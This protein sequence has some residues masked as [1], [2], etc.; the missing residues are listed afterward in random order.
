MTIATREKLT[1]TIDALSPT[2]ALPDDSALGSLGSGYGPN[3]NPGVSW[4][5]G[6]AGTKSYALLV[7]D[8]DVPADLSMVNTPGVV[9]AEHAPRQPFHHLVLV[10]VPPS[11]TR[12]ATGGDSQGVTPGGKPLGPTPHGVRGQNDYARFFNANPETT[13]PWGGYDGPCPPVNDAR[14]HRYAFRVFALD[15]PSL[16]LSGPF[17]GRAVQAA[18][19]G[20]TLALGEAIGTFT[21]NPALR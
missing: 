15:V 14:V 7:I 10:D 11:V 12:L 18:L 5:P 2:G 13:G 1:V 19:A 17:D 6:P 21:L 16:G 8:E 20:H 4:S 3:I 9:I